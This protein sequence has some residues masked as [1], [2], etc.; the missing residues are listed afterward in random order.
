MIRGSAT[1]SLDMATTVNKSRVLTI[2]LHPFFLASRIK[3]LGSHG[4]LLEHQESSGAKIIKMKGPYCMPVMRRKI[5]K[6]KEDLED[7]SQASTFFP[8][9]G[10][11]P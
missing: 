3:K 8:S 10:A 4:R 9:A 7:E 6:N 2:P 11:I 1:A 5:Q